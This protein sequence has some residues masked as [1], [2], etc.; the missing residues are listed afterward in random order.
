MSVV[1]VIGQTPCSLEHYLAS[2]NFWC[3]CEI[4]AKVP[5]WWQHELMCTTSWQNMASLICLAR[6][7]DSA[8]TN[9]S[10]LH[11]QIIARPWNMPHSRGW[12]SCHVL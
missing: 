10:A 2:S 7:C 6:T 12:R 1:D 5:V 4:D 3:C 8:L 11:T 9:W